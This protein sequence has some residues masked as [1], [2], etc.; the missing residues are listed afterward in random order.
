M[1][2]EIPEYRDVDDKRRLVTLLQKL[3]RAVNR[4]TNMTGGP[5]IEVHK[6]A[7]GIAIFAIQKRGGRV[8]PVKE[9]EPED[10]TGGDL[11]TLSMVIGEQDEDTWDR[12]SKNPVKFSVITDIGWDS[13][14]GAI[15]GR[16]REIEADKCGKL[17]TVGAEGAWVTL[18]E[19][20]V[21]PEDE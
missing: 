19:T 11:Q 5:G 9:S 14:N 4:V 18:V 2:I 16:L 12:S 6:T 13:E 10:C 17:K 20:D 1:A 3:S 21:C 7:G 8:G 15:V